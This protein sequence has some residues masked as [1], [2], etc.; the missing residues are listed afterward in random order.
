LT[1][2]F[3]VEKRCNLPLHLSMEQT[4]DK[5]L[6]AAPTI[7]NKGLRNNKVKINDVHY[8]LTTTS[9]TKDQ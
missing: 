6:T 8:G 1:A 7:S 4:T 5:S 9:E 3:S 2:Y